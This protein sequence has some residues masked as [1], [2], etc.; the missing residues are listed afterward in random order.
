MGGAHVNEAGVMEH[1]PVKQDARTHMAVKKM[2]S[3]GERRE[4]KRFNIEFLTEIATEDSEGKEWYEKTV[5]KDISGGGACFATKRTDRYFLGQELEMT[6]YL[7]GAGSVH[8]RM[9]ARARVVRIYKDSDISDGAGHGETEVAV[10]FDSLL[11][12][13]RVD[14]KQK[15]HA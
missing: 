6:F 9:K 12:F 3:A 10:Q 2:G 15:E 5:S 11:N 7:P 4:F 13:E 1:T 14:T 8:A